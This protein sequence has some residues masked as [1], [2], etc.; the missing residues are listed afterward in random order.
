MPPFCTWWEYCSSQRSIGKMLVDAVTKFTIGYHSGRTISFQVARGL[1]RFSESVSNSCSCPEFDF[2]VSSTGN[3]N[4]NGLLHNFRLVREMVHG[5]WGFFDAG[6]VRAGASAYT[7][8]TS[9]SYAP[10]LNVVG[11]RSFRFRLRAS[12]LQTFCQFRFCSLR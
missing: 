6:L 4:N 11:C 1:H 2:F 10:P 9:G 12:G 3:F 8:T 5:R 7:C